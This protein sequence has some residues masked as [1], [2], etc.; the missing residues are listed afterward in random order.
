MNRSRGCALILAL[1]AAAS[2]A[3]ARDFSGLYPRG[4][5]DRDQPRLESKVRKIFEIYEAGFTP[6]QARALA[7][8][9]IEC[10]VFGG[11]GEAGLFAYYTRGQTVTLS[12]LSLKF[13][14]DLCTAYAWLHVKGFSLETID[15]YVNLLKYRDPSSLKGGR[16][17]PPLEA[18]FIP[19]DAFED[20]KVND[21]SLRF[22]NSAFAFILGH[23]LGHVYHRHPG[24]APGVPRKQ[25]RQ[26]EEEADLFALDLME[27]TRTLPMGA[28]LFFQAIANY[29]PNRGDFRDDRAWQTFLES[30]ATH[31]LNGQRLR[32]L[33]GRLIAAEG[34][35]AHNAAE[36]PIVRFIAEGLVDVAE[37]LDDPDMQRVMVKVAREESLEDLRP[38]R[39][40]PP[41]PRVRP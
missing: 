41:R 35:F 5:L 20:A 11:P 13:L 24:Y 27:P 7:G 21:L 23:E 1:L 6:Q 2:P 22:R 29:M 14:E 3:T 16:F 28:I 9:R 25:A 19:A 12:I 31:P 36:R 40:K 10:P 17:P 34:R 38:R 33:S 15:E 26:N 37:T 30:E 4:E 8:V 18:L 39:P 32:A